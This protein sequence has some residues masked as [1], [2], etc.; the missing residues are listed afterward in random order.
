MNGVK[1]KKKKA[2]N[3]FSLLEDTLV[4]DAEKM[5]KAKKKN[6]WSAYG[7]REKSICN[8]KKKSGRL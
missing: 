6:K 7:R 3:D 8:W 5:V 4:E 1:S 2:K